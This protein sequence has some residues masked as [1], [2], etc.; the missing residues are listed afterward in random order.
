MQIKKIVQLQW[1]NKS[2]IIRILKRF[3][4]NKL[5]AQEIVFFFSFLIK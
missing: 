3:V 1:I 5:I 2:V 4:D